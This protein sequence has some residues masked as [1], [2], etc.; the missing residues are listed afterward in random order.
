MTRTPVRFAFVVGFS[1]AALFAVPLAPFARA[2]QKS[3]TLE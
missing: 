3:L 2:Q 1:V